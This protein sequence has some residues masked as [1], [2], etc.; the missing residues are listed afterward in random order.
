M[1]ATQAASVGV[2]YVA[3]AL[4][5]GV[6][7]GL[8]LYGLPDQDELDLWQAVRQ[9]PVNA[10]PADILA[11]CLSGIDNA[12]RPQPDDWIAIYG[13]SSTSAL[14]ISEISRLAGLRVILLADGVKHGGRLSERQGSILVDSHEPA[15][16]IKIVQSITK[17][18]LRFAVDTVGKET[19]GHLVQMLQADTQEGKRAHLVG[20][21][22]VP[23]DKI[24]GVVFHSVPIKLFHEVPSIGIA[25]MNWLERALETEALALPE[26][27]HADGGLSGINA[28]LDR[29]RRGEISGRRLVISV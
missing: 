3:A 11:E 22:G 27:E 2:A 12:E 10:I 7:L 1:P 28:A 29:M 9:V 8:K 15:R 19:A 4:A 26:V 16:A 14:F 25:L 6:S 20:L 21:T 24:E 13:G 18:K 5:L 23:Q 17:G